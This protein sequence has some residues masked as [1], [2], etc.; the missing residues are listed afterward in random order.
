MEVTNI[1]DEMNFLDG[2]FDPVKDGMKIYGGAYTGK[3]KPGF[4]YKKSFFAQ[5]GLTPT[6]ADSTWGEFMTLLEDIA[7]VQGVV[8]PIVSGDGVGWPLTDI[9]EHFI[10]TFGGA[11]LQ[12][13]L[14]AGTA[15]WTTGTVRDVFEDYLVPSLD[16]FSDPLEWSSTAI[17]SWWNEEYGLYF[18]GSWIT[19]MVADPSD[20]G[21]IPL[22]GADT[23]VF[24]GDY[25][26]MPQYT[27]HPE[28][29]QELFEFLVSEEAQRLQ[30]AQGGHLATNVNVPLASYPAVDRMVIESIS[31]AGAALDLDDTIGG[32]FQTTFFDQLKL[33]W[34]DPTKLNDVLAAIEAEAP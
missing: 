29:A 23:Y 9:T 10:L 21:I 20:L 2:T 34:V 8:D 33:L 28:E 22:P 12:K 6:T 30:V 18:M 3:V 25:F 24:V 27:E 31:G 32:E 4:W 15:S 1:I 7:D 13:D 11:Q 16:Y 19:G 14:I 26:F 5:H 17:T